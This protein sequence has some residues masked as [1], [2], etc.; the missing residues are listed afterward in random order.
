MNYK[1]KIVVKKLKKNG[2]QTTKMAQNK[3]DPIRHDG[4]WIISGEKIVKD[5]INKQVCTVSEV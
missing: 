4:Y 1:L 3:I 2:R 5:V